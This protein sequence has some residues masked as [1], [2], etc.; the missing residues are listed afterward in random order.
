MP[1]IEIT[2]GACVS[3]TWIWTC[4]SMRNENPSRL[5]A[6][7]EDSCASSACA[8]DVASAQFSVRIAVGTTSAL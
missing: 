2:F 8:C 5:F 7:I 1:T 3:G 6:S 4:R